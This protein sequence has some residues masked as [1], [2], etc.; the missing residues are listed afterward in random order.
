MT[1]TEI[2]DKVR[3]LTSG[4]SLG[5]ATDPI[6]TGDK[7][8]TL[9]DE[10]VRAVQEIFE[11]PHGT[12]GTYQLNVL[13]LAL[14]KFANAGNGQAK[15]VLRQI[16]G[17]EMRSIM[18]LGPQGC[19]DIAIRIASEWEKSSASEPPPSSKTTRDGI[20]H[21]IKE[22]MNYT[23]V[24]SLL[25]QPDFKENIA[26]REDC[27]WRKVNPEVLGLFV[28]FDGGTAKGIATFSKSGMTP[29]GSFHYYFAEDATYKKKIIGIVME[30][31]PGGD[32]DRTAKRKWWQFWR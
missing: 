8:V 22:G 29:R 2:R 31:L 13:A 28:S 16:A 4:D 15:T 5:A 6:G 9:G 19:A 10:A 17:G 3:K 26:S 14:E 25:G 11:N 23:E 21:K 18:S 30:G 20:Q 27:I 7:I 24:V 32:L 1:F 12:Y